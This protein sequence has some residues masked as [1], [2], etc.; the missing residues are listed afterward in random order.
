METE[1]SKLSSPIFSSATSKPRLINFVKF[2]NYYTN[3]VQI[4]TS[5]KRVH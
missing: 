1:F 4:Q 3:K 2:Q 5:F